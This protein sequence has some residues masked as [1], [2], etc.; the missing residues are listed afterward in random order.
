MVGWEEGKWREAEVGHY[1]E[2]VKPRDK[3]TEE[4]DGR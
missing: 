2:E 3:D 4:I 1:G